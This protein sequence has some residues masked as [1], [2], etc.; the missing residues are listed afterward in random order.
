MGAEAWQTS[1]E[2]QADQD[3]LEEIEE[4]KLDPWCEVCHYQ[5]SWRGHLPPTTH[6]FVWSV[7]MN[8]CEAPEGGN[9]KDRDGFYE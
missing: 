4:N 8:K 2:E 5:L 1:A 3:L 9:V 7:A 6:Y